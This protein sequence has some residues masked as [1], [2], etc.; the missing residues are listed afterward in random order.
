M[1]LNV[2]QDEYIGPLTIEAGV[3]VLLHAQGEMP[4]PLERGFSVSPGMATSV[5]MKKVISYLCLAN[6]Y[7]ARSSVYSARSLAL[8]RAKKCREYEKVFKRCC[9]IL[10]VV[11]FRPSL[12][13]LNLTFF[14]FRQK[15]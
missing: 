11:P 1:T 3:R 7:S 8:R 9:I 10:C 12:T 14:F 6:N 13:R 5:G 2:Q 15:Y 4:F